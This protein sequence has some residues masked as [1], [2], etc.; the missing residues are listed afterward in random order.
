MTAV[1]L[2]Q[3]SEQGNNSKTLKAYVIGGILSLLLTLAAFAFV[4]MKWLTSHELAIVIPVLA[5]LQLFVQTKFFLNL[6]SSPHGRWN[7]MS[8]LF[9]ILVVGVL[10]G[11]SLWIM[12]N[13]N[14]NMMH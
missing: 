2:S 11:G 9:T 12:I 13:L 3:S 8:F 1:H 10:I 5:L 14:Y 6:N 4:G 7:L